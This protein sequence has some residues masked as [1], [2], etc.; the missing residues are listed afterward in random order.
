[1]SVLRAAKGR[2]WWPVR[3]DLSEGGAA[4]LRSPRRP[5]SG[6]DTQAG[7]GAIAWDHPCA[8][9]RR[10]LDR[11]PG[12]QRAGPHADVVLGV[13]HPLQRLHHGSRSAFQNP[14]VRLREPDVASFDA[15][16]SA[17]RCWSPDAREGLTALTRALTKSPTHPD[18]IPDSRE[19]GYA[20]SRYAAGF[21]RIG[22]SDEG[23]DRAYH[24]DTGRCRRRTEVL[25][26]EQPLDPRDVLVAG[27]R[28]YAR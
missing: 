21:G 20:S 18:K 3:R 13:G 15:P 14:D 17:P 1:V 2:C 28:Q 6:G 26:P 25:A 9:R 19:S 11:V 16:S 4:L 5:G 22:T 10:R 23:R 7:K 27:G 24:L 8:V 12:G